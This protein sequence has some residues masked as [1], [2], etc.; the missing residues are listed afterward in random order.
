[1]TR[2][3]SVIA[4]YR[5]GQSLNRISRSLRIGK[6]LAW[7]ILVRYGEPRRTGRQCRMADGRRNAEIVTAHR[8]GR[9]RQHLAAEFGLSQQRIDQIL[10]QHGV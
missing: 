5:E 8:N 7:N 6:T 1:L 3:A 10:R 4:A 9:T 2:D